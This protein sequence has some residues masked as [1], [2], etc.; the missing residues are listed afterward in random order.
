MNYRSTMIRAALFPVP[1]H[2]EFLLWV[3]PVWERRRV[4]NR[5]AT[6]P[7]YPAS[8]RRHCRNYRL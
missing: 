2:P 4:S 8:P 3:V 5:R 1:R 7:A 6:P